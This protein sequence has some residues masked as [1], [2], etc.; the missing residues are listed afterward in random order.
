MSGLAEVS[1]NSLRALARGEFLLT[2]DISG[3]FL[4]HSKLLPSN[5]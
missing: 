2:E 5:Q 3:M 1:K 4:S